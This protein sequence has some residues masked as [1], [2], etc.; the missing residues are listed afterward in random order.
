MNANNWIDHLQHPLVLA[1]FGLFLF[2]FALVIRPLFLSSSKLS[3]A[4]ILA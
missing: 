1:G 4:A 2:I 3:G